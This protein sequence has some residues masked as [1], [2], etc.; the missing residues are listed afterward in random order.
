MP[1]MGRCRGSVPRS[2]LCPPPV[3]RREPLSGAGRHHPDQTERAH[4]G[5][6]QSG[7]HRQHH[8]AGG[9]RVR[10]ELL[11]R[12]VDAPEEIQTHHQHVLRRLRPHWE[13]LHVDIMFTH[14]GISVHVWG[15]GDTWSRRERS[16]LGYLSLFP[17]VVFKSADSGCSRG[18]PLDPRAS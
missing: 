18:E 1:V 16:S 6:A 10:N 7:R 2:D 9:H 4:G 13:P 12:T 5:F 8:H 3:S 11:H 14:P 17:L 15:G